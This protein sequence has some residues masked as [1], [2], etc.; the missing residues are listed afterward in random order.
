MFLVLVPITTQ[1]LQNAFKI[2]INCKWCF[3]LLLYILKLENGIIWKFSSLSSKCKKVSFVYLQF[4]FHIFIRSSM[5]TSIL[6]SVS[7]RESVRAESAEIS[8]ILSIRILRS[9]QLAKVL[10]ET[11]VVCIII[12]P[13]TLSKGIQILL[14]LHGARKQ[15]SKHYSIFRI[16]EYPLKPLEMKYLGG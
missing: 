13:L 1:L 16:L 5:L 6:S 8:F 4:L 15:I 11:I 10:D 12:I 9:Y 2:Y 7:S 14:V 3:N